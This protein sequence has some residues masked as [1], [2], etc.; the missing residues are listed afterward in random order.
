ME[1]WTGDTAH[2]HQTSRRTALENRGRNGVPRVSTGKC[3]PNKDRR[4][5]SW[6]CC[7]ASSISTADAGTCWVNAPVIGQVNECEGFKQEGSSFSAQCHHRCRTQ[8]RQAA[9]WGERCAWTR[10]RNFAA[11][12]GRVSLYRHE[13]AEPLGSTAGFAQSVIGVSG[14]GEVCAS[15]RDRRR[16]LP[17]IQAG[18]P[19]PLLQ[20]KS[21]TRVLVGAL[22]VSGA[23]RARTPR[24]RDPMQPR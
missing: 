19:P 20:T 7:S 23:Q 12:G 13:S 2:A 1:S 9:G 21:L 16:G 17:M 8:G 10:E 3:S 5:F 6:Q 11:R 15:A 24:W 14:R 18:R 22:G 4:W